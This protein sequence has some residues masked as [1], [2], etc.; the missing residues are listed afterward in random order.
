MAKIHSNIFQLVDSLNS[1]GNLS[2][3]FHRT[4]KEPLQFSNKDTDQ[5]NYISESEKNFYYKWSEKYP[6]RDFEVPTSK[7]YPKSTTKSTGTGLK[8][9]Y[10]KAICNL[11]YGKRRKKDD[12]GNLL[13]KEQR[14]NT[15]DIELIFFE[16]FGRVYVLV[17]TSNY[18]HLL[19]V[20]KLIG[21]S[22]IK[23]NNE[24]YSLEPDMFNWL[25]FVY[26]ERQGKLDERLS[27]KNISGFIGN[28]LD[29][30][31]TIKGTS[32]QATEL[33]VTKAFIS[34]GGLLRSV[35]LRVVDENVDLVFSLTDS[36]M[37]II[38]CTVSKKLQLLDPLVQDIY[39]ILYAYTYLIVRLKNDYNH[40]SINFH[41]E[42]KPM[43]SKKIGLE[44]I[45]SIMTE[46]NIK[47]F[48]LNHDNA[49]AK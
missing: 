28:V 33:I 17:L 7:V 42:E 41:N 16:L 2:K 49:K 11:E 43:F 39:F 8:V 38:D 32:D 46:N 24:L 21:I 15:I 19:R 30:A 10:Q 45:T 34:N 25:V 36:S 9:K 35:T 47:Y 20:K 13:P 3:I 44:V 6:I 14:L 18:Y 29:S 4:Y 5:A 48:E 22:N 37:T 1:L 27:L 12:R 23:D 26:S 40:E 31:N